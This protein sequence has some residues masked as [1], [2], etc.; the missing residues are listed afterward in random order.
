MIPFAVVHDGLHERGAFLGV[1]GAFHGAGAIAGGLGAGS[2]IGRLGEVRAL[3]LAL[4]LGAGG[5][6]CY[7]LATSRARCSRRCSSAAAW[8]A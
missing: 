3:A 6:A 2:F 7:T 1:L 4:A 8:P 5:M